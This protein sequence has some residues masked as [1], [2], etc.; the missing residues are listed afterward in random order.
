MIDHLDNLLRYLF[1]RK[2]AN[3]RE[4]RVRFEPP[5]DTWRQ[6]VSAQAE[7]GPALNVYLADLRENR[8]L[9]SNERVREAR[10][11]TLMDVPVPRRVDCHYLISAWSAATATVSTAPTLDE[12]RLL[13]QAAA[14]LMNAEPLV[15]SRVY[16]PGS[17]PAGFPARFADEELPTHVLPPEGFP[18]LAEFWGAMG[19]AY[20]WKPVVYL[21]ATL[22]VVLES[23]VAGPPVTTTITDYRAE[24]KSITTAALQIGGRVLAGSPARAAAGAWVQLLVAAGG[25]L[26]VTHTDADGRFV[27]SGLQAGHY[28]LRVRAQGFAEGTRAI[29][30]PSATGDYDIHLS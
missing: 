29:E 12:H 26:G 27:F 1:A 13:Y 5:T 30:L 20:P 24:G 7:A 10:N 25:A 11:G 4:D 9:R 15:A 22:P 19:T 6:T 16:P 2:I 28:S 17:L 23:M 3:L 8:I 14:V 21:V 18:K